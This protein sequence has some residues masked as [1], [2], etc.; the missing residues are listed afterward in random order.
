M[1]AWTPKL[2][3]LIQKFADAEDKQLKSHLNAK[4]TA[5][6]LLSFLFNGAAMASAYTN[7]CAEAGLNP[8][9]TDTKENIKTMI[10]LAQQNDSSSADKIIKAQ[11]FGRTVYQPFLERHSEIKQ[12]SLRGTYKLMK[13]AKKE[14]IQY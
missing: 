13:A 6:A 3:Q 8:A 11:D 1:T 9:R 12:D 4:T 10:E 7:V 14:K 5:G 2:E